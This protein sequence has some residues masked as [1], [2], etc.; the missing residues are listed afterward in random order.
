MLV[1]TRE[2][3]LIRIGQGLYVRAVVSPV[4]NRPALPKSHNTLA[5]ETLKRLDIPIAPT[6]MERCYNG[7]RTTQVLAGRV[8]GVRKRVCRVIGFDGYSLKFERTT[9]NSSPEK[10]SD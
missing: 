5:Q 10:I 7:D 9:E 2:G 4:D 1:L 3:V 8:I 6:S